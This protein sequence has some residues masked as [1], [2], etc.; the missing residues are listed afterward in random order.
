MC[1]PACT[2]T[3]VCGHGASRRASALLL[4]RSSPA[5]GG[6]PA[7]SGFVLGEEPGGAGPGARTPGLAR[8]PH[9]GAGLGEE[10]AHPPRPPVSLKLQSELLPAG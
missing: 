3:H 6:G 7:C 1:V 5:P 10:G 8:P 9:P 4:A 2:L